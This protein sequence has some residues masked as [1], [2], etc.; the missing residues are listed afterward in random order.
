MRTL[1]LLRLADVPR[2]VIV[3]MKRRQSVAEH[4]FR[5]AVIA[6]ELAAYWMGK[7]GPGVEV[8]MAA[9]VHDADE[10][11]TGDVPGNLKRNYPTLKEN[12]ERIAIRERGSPIPSYTP[13]AAA[14]VKLADVV[15][16]V[17]YLMMWGLGNTRARLIIHELMEAFYG[18]KQT[19]PL[20][21]WE[22]AEFL[23]G[24]IMEEADEPSIDDS[25]KGRKGGPRNR[26]VPGRADQKGRNIRKFERPAPRAVRPGPT[27]NGS[28]EGTA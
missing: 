4:S 1:D 3:P 10:A 24:A 7:K 20:P 22:R 9:I 18:L 14:V 13:E 19:V 25:A 17:T 8:V 2:W 26:K 28:G 5:V 16:T 15:E 11:Y 27:G 21:V 6:G 12:L 23:L